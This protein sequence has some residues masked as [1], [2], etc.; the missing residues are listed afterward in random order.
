[1]ALVDQVADLRN[2]EQMRVIVVGPTT[3]SP[4][5][6]SGP[7]HV[8][9]AGDFFANF[10]G[11]FDARFRVH[12]FKAGR[13][14]AGAALAGEDLLADAAD[15]PAYAPWSDQP[16]SLEAV[17]SARDRFVR[18]IAQLTRQL[19]EYKIGY[20]GVTQAISIVAHYVTPRLV[21]DSGPGRRSAVVRIEVAAEDEGAEFYLAGVTRGERGG[22]ARRVGEVFVL[23]TVLHYS[24]ADIIG[25]HVITMPY[26]ACVRLAVRRR[27]GRDRSLDIPLPTPSVLHANADRGLPIHHISVDWASRTTSGW[28]QEDALLEWPGGYEP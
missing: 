12:D 3:F 21:R 24:D 27:T 10:G 20:L 13:A 28:T 8:K 18:R 9:L 2:R 17:P 7:V 14:L 4:A 16:P 1:M 19:L 25:P 15:R 5:D 6:G 11:F 22:D 23:H 26:G